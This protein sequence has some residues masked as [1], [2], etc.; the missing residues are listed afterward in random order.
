MKHFLILGIAFAAFHISYSETPAFCQLPADEGEG[1]QF[2]FAIYYDATQDV[3][4]P[5]IYKGEGGNANR[6][7][8][9][10]ECIRNCSANAENIYPMEAVKNCVLKKEKGK[11]NANHVRYYYD[12]ALDLCKLFTWTGCMGNGNR[13]QTLQQCN[14]TCD[15][16]HDDLF[17]SED[18]ETDTPYALIFGVLLGIMVAAGILT[19]VLLVIQSKKKKKGEKKRDKKA[20]SPLQD[21]IEMS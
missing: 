16:V 8:S 2:M 18:D 11:C 20:E 10:K 1:T 15:G 13:F 12:A 14:S 5:F 6:F 4:G 9:E 21:G 3:C 17:P 7:A 19:A